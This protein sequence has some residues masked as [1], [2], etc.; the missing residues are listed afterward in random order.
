MSFFLLL[1]LLLC[2]LFRFLLCFL[3]K[4]TLGL[5]QQPFLE[6]FLRH[7]I[8]VPVAVQLQSPGHLFKQLVH[9]LRTVAEDNLRVQAVMLQKFRVVIAD[10]F[11]FRFQCIAF[12]LHL[13][14]IQ[15]HLCLHGLRGFYSALCCSGSVRKECGHLYQGVRIRVLTAKKTPGSRRILMKFQKRFYDLLGR[16]LRHQF[17]TVSII[18]IR[19][20]FSQKI[21]RLSPAL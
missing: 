16:F 11:H 1:C 7:G 8:A 20:I 13:L 9:V 19:A 4:L 12:R 15:S 17:L 18:L 6:L 3:L 2:F 14:V 5:L 10:L 21:R